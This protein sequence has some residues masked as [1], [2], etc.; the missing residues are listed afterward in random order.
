MH[1]SG[2]IK[3][4]HAYNIGLL[5]LSRNILIVTIFHVLDYGCEP[6]PNIALKRVKF[7]KIGS[8]MFFKM[9]YCVY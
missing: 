4:S 5:C 6:W 1:G 9:A 7:H 2:E 3:V 8:F